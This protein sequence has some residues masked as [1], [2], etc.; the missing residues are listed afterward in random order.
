VRSFS[1]YCEIAFGSDDTKF[2]PPSPGKPKNGVS[3]GAKSIDD[4]PFSPGVVAVPSTGPK[5]GESMTRVPPI[6]ATASANERL[7]LPS[8]NSTDDV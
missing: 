2:V 3:P 8:L 1:R 7:P 6:A 4:Q 5:P